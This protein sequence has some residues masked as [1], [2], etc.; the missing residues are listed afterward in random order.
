MVKKIVIPCVTNGGV[1]PVEFQVGVPAKGNQ[2]IEFQ[3]KWLSSTNRG[4]V[5]PDV[6]KALMD[7]YEVAEESNLDFSELCESAFKEVRGEE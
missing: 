3:S 2:P 6:L 1:L 7:L 5:P 4:S